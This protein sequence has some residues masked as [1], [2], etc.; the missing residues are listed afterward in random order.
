MQ[1]NEQKPFTT[2]Q[3][4]EQSLRQHWQF[5][6]CF[7]GMTVVSSKIEEKCYVSMSRAW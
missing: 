7:K 2:A 4:S 5:T 3:V 1:V 6:K